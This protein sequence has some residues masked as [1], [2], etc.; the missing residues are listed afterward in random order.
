MPFGPTRASYL[1][2]V[3]TPALAQVETDANEAFQVIRATNL[4][5]AVVEYD[6]IQ[7]PPDNQWGN[8]TQRHARLTAGAYRT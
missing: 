7:F 8:P 1:G 4:S 2:R 5:H 3:P 6:P